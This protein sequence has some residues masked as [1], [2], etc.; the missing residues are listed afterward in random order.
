MQSAF[1][2][3]PRHMRAAVF[4][5]MVDDDPGQEGQGQVVAHRVA[6]A[7]V[8]GDVAVAQLLALELQRGD[9]D[10]AGAEYQ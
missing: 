2:L 7:G 9:G 1:A 5:Q 6:P 8:G 4:F 3:G 10:S